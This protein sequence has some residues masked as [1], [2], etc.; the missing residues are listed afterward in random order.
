MLE[1]CSE[2]NWSLETGQCLGSAQIFYGASSLRART[3]ITRGWAG[4]TRTRLRL[5]HACAWAIMVE[6]DRTR[7]KKNQRKK[8]VLLQACQYLGGS[9]SILILNESEK[10]MNKIKWNTG[11]HYT[12]HGQRIAACQADTGVIVV[13]IDR[14]LEY[15]FPDCAFNQAAIM[16]RYLYNENCQYISC[17]DN[18][19][20]ELEL[21]AKS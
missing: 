7:L 18:R 1:D 6:P 4:I 21:F 14:G 13:D 8:L 2:I 17:T 20:K 19:V 3:R 10:E 5:A 16:H 15:L 11:A 12:A 9:V